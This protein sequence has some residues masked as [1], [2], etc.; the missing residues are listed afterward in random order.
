LFLTIS[1]NSLKMSLKPIVDGAASAV[2]AAEPTG[3]NGQPEWVGLI[4]EQVASLRFGI[5]Q[6]V[7]HEGRVVQIEK[8]EK[9]R[10]TT[11]PSNPS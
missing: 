9:H 2:S 11:R 7:V 1:I 4:R 3:S 5:I 8:T 6:V 10:L